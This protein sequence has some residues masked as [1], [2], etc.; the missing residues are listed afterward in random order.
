MRC[1]RHR[2]LTMHLFIKQHPVVS[3]YTSTFAISWGAILILV[4]PAGFFRT[5]A[6]SPTFTLVGFARSWVPASP[7][8]C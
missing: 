5:T 1:S 4:G 2:E 7:A 8:S 6:T 3:Y